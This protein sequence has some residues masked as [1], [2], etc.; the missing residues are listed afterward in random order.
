MVVT[1]RWHSRIPGFV[2]AVFVH[3]A[4]QMGTTM[5]ADDVALKGTVVD[6]EGRPI[7]M[8][9]VYVVR[10][11]W[12]N[13][14]FKMDSLNAV[15]AKDGSYEFAKAY[16]LDE[17]S[18]FVVSVAHPGYA[19]T[20]LV[21]DNDS[22]KKLDDGR[23]IL[24]AAIP[25]TIRL[26]DSDGKPLSGIEFYPSQRQ[27]KDGRQHLLY[28]VIAQRTK[29]LWTKTDTDGRATVT[30]FL[31]KD[32]AT[33]VAKIGD[34]FREV[35]I[36]VGDAKDLDVPVTNAFAPAPRQ[37]ADAKLVDWVKRHAV[38]LKSIDPAD[39]DFSD[40]LPMKAL[41]GER[42]IVLLGEQSHGDGA[43]FLA[44]TRLIR[45]LHQEMGF[46]VLAFES[47]LYDCRRAA[48]AFTDGPLP[49]AAA[50]LGIFPIW[51]GSKE[52]QPLIAYLGTTAGKKR[53]LELAG[54]D[55][56]MTGF[57][58]RRHLNDD[59]KSLF[60][61]LRIDAIDADSQ[62]LFLTSLPGLARNEP[63]EDR[64][65]RFVAICG[66]VEKACASAGERRD[67][68]S[69]EFQFWAQYFR[70]LRA[71]ARQ[72][73]SK[74]DPVAS[75]N[76]RD[77]Q[78][79]ENLAWLVTE[80]YP[81]RKII[82]WA[83]S[84]HLAKNPQTILRTDGAALYEKTKTMGHELQSLIDKRECF[85][86]GF[87]SFT[88]NAGTWF[89]PP[90]PV[91]PVPAGSWEHIFDGTGES[92]LFLSLDQSRDD[93][94]WLSEKRLARPLG[95]VPLVADWTQVFDAFVFIRT[96]TPSTRVDGQSPNEGKR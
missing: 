47:G 73:T 11:T 35:R 93:A 17:R 31:P 38:P 18:Q 67:N 96:M 40:V 81:K 51:T 5:A 45:F 59:V 9:Q 78:M 43:A 34:A 10:K 92:S 44:K 71:Y 32:K 41:I 33:I 2:V 42:R 27:S 12:P 21:H 55:D 61:K 87:T 56:Q 77:R 30:A 8:V 26:T 19:L 69:S 28:P 54:F 60:E 62:E 53:P 20:S 7:P 25:V 46:D 50:Q 14:R 4:L 23:L 13:S 6:T 85:T 72:V 16:V 89:Q 88:G 29:S 91:P 74:Q 52:V 75:S 80:L 65:E 24:E 66:Q 84:F 90:H 1:G 15:T 82:V 57:A 94:R 76:L 36:D 3:F 70:S 37:P 86:I 63:L 39:D 83:A 22:G 58:S 79:A 95:Y 68:D 48:R 64:L 49:L